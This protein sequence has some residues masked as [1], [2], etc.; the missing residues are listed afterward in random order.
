M[1][2][3]SSFRKPL[4][5]LLLLAVVILAPLNSPAYDLISG[6]VKT[7]AC[8]SAPADCCDHDHRELPENCPGNSS[9]DCCDHEECGH[10]SIEQAPGSGLN[11]YPS[12]RQVFHSKPGGAFPKVYLSIFVPPES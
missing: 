12:S 5:T 6:G 4:T 9:G 11:M 7:C 8:F 10:D 2:T 1:F 3:I